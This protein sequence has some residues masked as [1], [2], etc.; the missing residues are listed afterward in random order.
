MGQDDSMEKSDVNEEPSAYVSCYPN[1]RRYSV[2]DTMAANRSQYTTDNQ[3]YSEDTDYGDDEK[4]SSEREETKIDIPSPHP[5][6][7]HS[8]QDKMADKKVK[9]SIEALKSFLRKKHS[10]NLSLDPVIFPIGILAMSYKRIGY[11]FH[12]L[13]S[14][15]NQPDQT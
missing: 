2:A 15:G 8:V 14:L 6:S 7:Y 5:P 10:I 1:T 12:C 3:G 13:H 4:K 11:T 9:V